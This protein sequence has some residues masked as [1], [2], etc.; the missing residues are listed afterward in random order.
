MASEPLD[1]HAKCIKNSARYVSSMEEET[2]KK[3]RELQRY[4]N[5]VLFYNY[6]LKQAQRE[7]K[8]KFD[9]DRYKLKDKSLL[10]D[11]LFIESERKRASTYAICIKDADHNEYWYQIET[12]K[13]LASMHEDDLREALSVSIDLTEDDSIFVSSMTT[14]ESI[15]I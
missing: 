1:W 5:D 8:L 14:M 9:A 7:G 2:N 3:L 15:E 4:R 11:C 6:Q 10:E 13:P 12:E